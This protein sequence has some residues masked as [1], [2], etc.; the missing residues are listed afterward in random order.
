LMTIL[1]ENA[2]TCTRAVLTADRVLS[3]PVH[4]PV[5]LSRSLIKTFA[6]ASPAGEGGAL[7]FFMFAASVYIWSRSNTDT[8]LSCTAPADIYNDAYSVVAAVMH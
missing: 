7:N 5:H 2:T 3:S 8:H 6:T 1:A 4:L